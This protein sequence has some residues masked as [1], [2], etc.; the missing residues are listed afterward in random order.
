M[1]FYVAAYYCKE[2]VLIDEE[3]QNFG[4]YLQD[5]AHCRF[6]KGMCET[7]SSLTHADEP[8]I[9]NINCDQKLKLNQFVNF[10]VTNWEAHQTWYH[11]C[12]HSALKKDSPFCLVP[13]LWQNMKPPAY[14][15]DYVKDIRNNTLTSTANAPQPVQ[16]IN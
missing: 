3:H 5:A 14:H 1:H 8:D 9:F 7:Y 11:K 16:K 15:H 4:L 13:G 12:H 2:I 6:L 10:A